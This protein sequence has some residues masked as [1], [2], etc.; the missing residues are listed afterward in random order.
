MSPTSLES[1]KPKIYV[2][3]KLFKAIRGWKMKTPTLDM[4]MEGTLNLLSTLNLLGPNAL[5]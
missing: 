1:I 3:L 4:S 2:E 5:F